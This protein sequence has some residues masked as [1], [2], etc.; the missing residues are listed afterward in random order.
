L[1]DVESSL[2]DSLLEMYGGSQKL[3]LAM[4]GSIVAVTIYI[5][6]LTGAFNKMKPISVSS[7]NGADQ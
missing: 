4:V 6:Y 7:R 3:L 1:I 2:D 5:Y